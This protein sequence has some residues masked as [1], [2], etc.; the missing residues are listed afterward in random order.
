MEEKGDTV[1]VAELSGSI[2]VLPNSVKQGNRIKIFGWLGF[3]DEI[4]LPSP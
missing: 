1:K 4:P 3:T 2:G